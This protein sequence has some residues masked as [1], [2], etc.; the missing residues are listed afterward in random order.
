MD[1]SVE[2]VRQFV[3][4]GFNKIHLDTSVHLG[5]N[6]IKEKL[7]TKLITRRGVILCG[8]AEN[9]FAEFKLLNLKTIQPVYIVASEVPIS[10]G[11]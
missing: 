7:D 10:G 11:S 8:V 1:E 6:N 2:L 4:A 3:L 9:V 5:D